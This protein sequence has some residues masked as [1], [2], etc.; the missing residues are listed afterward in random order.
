MQEGES[1]KRGSE[2]I[3]VRPVM[4]STCFHVLEGH[5]RLAIAH[6]RGARQARALIKQ[7][8]ALTPLQELLLDASWLKGRRELYQPINSPE[9]AGWTLVRRC[10]D[11]LTKMTAF[12]RAE[13]LMPPVCG[14]YLD[15]ASC[16][17]WFVSGMAKAGFRAEGVELDPTAIS[18]GTLMYGLT[19]DQV[20]RGDSVAFLQSLHGRYDVTSCLSLMHHYLL[21]R[22]NVS[23]EELLRLLDAATGRVMFFDMGQSHEYPDPVLQEWD[24]DHI[25]RWLETNTTFK[26]IVRLGKDEDGVP[27]NQHDFGRMLFAC[28]R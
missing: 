22:K 17:G 5:H 19:P 7:P 27:P 9:V 16:Y 11:R 20:R 18:I 25:H 2:E 21:S 23:A 28:V 4:Y 15:V 6:M 1:Y 12:L 13:G 14:S 10:S 8:A 3:A 26:R 24:P